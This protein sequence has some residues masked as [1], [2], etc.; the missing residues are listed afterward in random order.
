MVTFIGKKRRY[1]HSS[2][3]RVVIS[4]FCKQK[5][6]IPVVLLIIAKYLQVMFESL[7]CLFRLC[8]TFGMVTGGVVEVHI[9]CFSK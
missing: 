5:K 6:C 1:S 3:R 4:E 9:K 7:V 8:I 2:M